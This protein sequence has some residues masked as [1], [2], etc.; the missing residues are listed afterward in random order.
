M[1]AFRYQAFDGNGREIAGVIEA[2]SEREA[3][4]LVSDQGLIVVSATQVER[5]AAGGSGGGAGAASAWSR[6][7][8]PGEVTR[9]TRE[10][11]LLLAAGQTLTGALTLVEADE[12]TSRVG[13]LATRLRRGLAEGKALH[14]AMATDAVSFPPVF[15]GM[16]KAAE[17]SGKLA[18]VLDRIADTR[19][20]EQ[21]L[22]ARITSAL[23]YPSFLVVAS[24]AAIAVLMVVVVPRFKDLLSESSG[25]LPAS[26]RAVLVASDWLTTN[27][28]GLLIG[29]PLTAL[30]SALLL[31]RPSGQRI[32]E[33]IALRLPLIGGIKR[34]ALAAR[35]C[36]ALGVLLASGLGLAEALALTRN[37]VGSPRAEALIDQISAAL[38]QG[39]D[40]TEPLSR[41]RLFPAMVTSLLRIGAE[42]GSLSQQALRLADMYESKLD[43]AI[44]R[45]MSVLEPLIILLVSAI[46]GFIV[47]SIVGAI[48]GVY[49]L[50]GA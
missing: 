10:L 24:L 2:A 50:T 25:T 46:I 21:K 40:F 45:L 20:R 15:V 22:R 44:G 3:L 35:F 16:V 33:S 13:G 37:V 38:R 1:T 8:S 18:S 39:Q 36:R 41:A 14:E 19:E 48:M 23:I 5:T 43:I 32:I 29:L 7:V 42:S 49:D 9:L 31:R 27:A 6:V 26:S 4:R 12:G 30:V 11:A 28:W 47:L 17:A 34:M